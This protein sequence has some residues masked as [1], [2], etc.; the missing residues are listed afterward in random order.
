M[1]K[2]SFIVP[3]YKPKSVFDK[4]IKSLLDQSL[5]DW[6]AIFVLDG[7]STSA[8]ETI[9]QLMKK[10]ANHYKIIEIDHAGANR[11]RNTGAEAAKGDYW[12]FW[13]SD[14]IIEPDAAKAWVD[15]LDK[16]PEIGFVYSGYKFLNEQGAINSEPF[17]PW[18][19][20][21][22]NYISTCFP[23][24]KE[25]FPGWD[26]SL[27]S[28]QDWD[29][30]LSVVEKGGIGKFLGGYAFSTAFPDPDSISGKGCTDDVWLERVDAVKKKHGLEER[31]AC[32]S[33]L[34]YKADGI[35]LAKLIN[36][37]Y[38]DFPNHK[39]N[40]YKTIIQLGFSLVPSRVEHHAAMF[41]E[42]GLKKVLFWTGDNIDEIYN[43]IS[44][45]AISKYSILLN[46]SVKQYV[47]D[48]SAKDMMERAGFEVEVL[49]VPFENPK[50]PTLLPE[51]P[52]FAVDISENYGQLFEILDRSLPDIELQQLKGE[53]KIDDYTGLLHFYDDRTMSNGIKRMLLAGRQVI[54]NVKAPF[55]G[56]V[57]D[58]QSPDYFIP[59]LVEKVRSTARK[60]INTAAREYYLREL[61]K[62]KF[63]EVLK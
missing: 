3:V 32:V 13:D 50:E 33:S 5:R 46:G 41:K 19:L 11:A 44:F 39:P 21:V 2:L 10:R 14:C 30:W 59:A 1:P 40:R 28:L 16:N 4:V 55:A 31:Q 29:F 56:F 18:L 52:K 53:H 43:R 37:D 51:K 49:P 35:R 63:L 22:R 42:K 60:Q 6:E 54:S 34:L 38:Q 20:R 17:D 58:L 48:K 15:I 47:E 12:V 61:D 27:K 23:L 26:E 36:A 45:N 25:L 62:T 8:K 24:R 9:H 7:P 57:D